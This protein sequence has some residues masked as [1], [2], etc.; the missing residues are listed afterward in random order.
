MLED[1]FNKSTFAI[2]TWRGD[3]Q[4]CWLDQVLEFAVVG[5][6]Q[7]LRSAPD[8]CQYTSLE[9]SYILGDRELTPEAVSAVERNRVARRDLQDTCRFLSAPW[10]L[11]CRID[12]LVHRSAAYLAPRR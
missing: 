10:I 1:W 5:R 8:Q 9:P 2:A 12:H 11:H 7:W 6:D 3:A 4:R